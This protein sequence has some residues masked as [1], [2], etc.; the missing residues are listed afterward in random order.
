MSPQN[1]TLQYSKDMPRQQGLLLRGSRWFCN[2]KVPLELRA[3][4]GKEHIREA[5]GTSDHRE[6]CRKVA[7]ERAHWTAVFEN[8]LKKV[9]VLQAPPPSTERTLLTV[10]SRQEAHEMAIRYLASLEHEFRTWMQK[11]GR[12]LEPHELDEI[13]ST[14]AED[15]YQLA[16]GQEFQG[17]RLDGTLELQ[18]F[19]ESEQR[20]CA[21][22]SPAFQTLRP[23]FF[24][25]RLEYFERAKDMLNGEAVRERSHLF[26]GVHSYST[27]TLKKAKGP[28]VDDILALRQRV[29]KKLKR[30]EKTVDASK[31]P[32]RLLREYFGGGREV[33]SISREDMHQLFDLLERVPPNA[34]KRYKGMTLAQAVAAADK[35]G[36]ERRLSPKTLQNN[37]IQIRTIFKMAVAELR[38]AEDPT[39]SPLLR[40]SF[41][42][43]V[44]T[45]PREQFTIDE[46]N[47]LFRAPLYSGCLDDERNFRMPGKSHPKR[48]RFWVPLLALFHGTRCNEACQIHTEDVK[49]RDGILFISIREEEEDGSKCEKRLKTKQSRREVPVHPELIRMG[50]AEFVES[51]RRDTSSPR[52]F[53]ELTL[54]HKGYPSDAFSKWFTRFVQVTLGESCKARMHSFRHQF[55]DATRAAGLP[56]ET[57]GLLAGWEAGEGPANRQMNHYG[58]GPGF[59]HTLAKDLAKVKHPG[60]DLSHLYPSSAAIP[61]RPLH[62]LR[63]G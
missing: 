6:A 22:T 41:E 29:I 18:A 55:R 56:V 28:T 58:R 5:L 57:V 32:A 8:E 16:T 24:D 26:K 2:F 1:V 35:A 31:L 27:A 38:L 19:L 61:N 17:K 34:T 53:P 63:E 49:T 62:R 37:F 51:R 12:F 39:D 20:E 43:E 21:V 10:V 3:A 33:S 9:Q 45:K 60:L 30:S 14:L 54:G 15:K 13:Q 50:F 52:L 23:L 47:L 11:E 42:K 40:Q 48:G 59:L 7:Y 4:L 36:D 46:L 44:D 25:A